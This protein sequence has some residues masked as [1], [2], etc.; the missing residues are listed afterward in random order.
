MLHSTSLN[1]TIRIPNSS[2]CVRHENCY[3]LGTKRAIRDPLV[4]KRPKKILVVHIVETGDGPLWQEQDE[5]S[6]LIDFESVSS[7]RLH[8]DNWR[9]LHLV[10]IKQRKRR[11]YTDF[12]VHQPGQCTGKFLSLLWKPFPNVCLL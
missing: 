1:P 10:R 12:I 4:S 11:K 5:K 9:H 7:E 6:L 2:S 3:I 8:Y